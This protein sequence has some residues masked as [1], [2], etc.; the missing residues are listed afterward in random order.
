MAANTWAP[1]VHL[2]TPDVLLPYTV[3]E[4]VVHTEE[5]TH[6]WAQ[7]T[8]RYELSSGFR[9][10]ADQLPP[11]L[12][13]A[14]DTPVLVSWGS[15]PAAREDFV[16]YVVSPE[17][18]SHPDTQQQHFVAAQMLDVRYTLLGASKILQTSRTHTWR[19]CTVAYMAQSIAA[20]NSLAAVTDPHGR[21]FDRV[22]AS[23]SDFRY[24]Q[25]RAAEVGYR[26][27]VQGTTLYLT[28]PRRQLVPSVPT[29]RQS[30]TPGMADSMQAFRAVIGET[31]PAGAIR[32]THT[33]V[34]VS[35]AGVV[36]TAQA[37][38]QRRSV[39]TGADVPPQ[40]GRY[41][42]NYPTG[43]Y[44]TAQAVTSAA[45]LADLWWVHA[46]ATLDGDVRLRPGCVVSLGGSAL[47]SQYAG[48]W[49]VRC[50]H[51]RLVVNQLNPRLSTYYADVELGRDQAAALTHVPWV[52]GPANSAAAVNGRWTARRSSS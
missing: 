18:I 1:W 3:Q 10:A 29:Y 24:L 42:S 2:T 50:A 4:W 47:T 40:V 19:Q 37:Q 26:L 7:L 22:Q 6:P 16:G 44:A 9:A 13:W 43:S 15:N 38:Q 25:D 49:M 8:L 14:E 28:D 36:T 17:L 5:G 20:A 35:P 12:W 32:A 34:A 52:P 33:A 48:T 41:A 39:V 27:A 11:T 46:A 45:A 21:V 51:H 31:D 23:L 30:R